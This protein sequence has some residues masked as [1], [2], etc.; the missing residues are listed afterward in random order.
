MYKRNL[1]EKALDKAIS[2]DAHERHTKPS[3]TQISSLAEALQ[4]EEAVSRHFIMNNCY[5]KLSDG[6]VSLKQYNYILHLFYGNN[7]IKLC[8]VLSQFLQI[9]K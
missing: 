8:K 2:K 7:K 3:I 5:E 4:K 1:V 9:K 6:I